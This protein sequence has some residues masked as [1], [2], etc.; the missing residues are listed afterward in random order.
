MSE[1]LDLANKNLRDEFEKRTGVK[2]PRYV[3]RIRN[4]P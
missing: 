3:S 4:Q 2:L 1:Y